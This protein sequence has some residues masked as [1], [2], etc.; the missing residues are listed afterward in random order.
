MSTPREREAEQYLS[1]HKIMELMNNL[2]SMLFFYRPERPKEF[3]ISQ[4]EQLK[5]SRLRAVDSPCLF[6]DSNLDAVFGILD[7]T[8]QG[9]ITCT[10]YQEAMTTLGIRNVNEC[11]EDLGSDRISRKTFKKG[12]KESLLSSAATFQM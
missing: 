3:L 9:Y 5:T 7:P 4:L 2:T 6:D 12:A 1:N 8:N 11:P 10:Q